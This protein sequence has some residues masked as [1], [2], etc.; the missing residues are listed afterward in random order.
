MVDGRTR[1][2]TECSKTKRRQLNSE[3]LLQKSIKLEKKMSV[4]FAVRMQEG[5]INEGCYERTAQG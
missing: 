2:A 1:Q 5:V 3:K 4:I